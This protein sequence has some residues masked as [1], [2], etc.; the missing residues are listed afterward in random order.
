MTE[1]EDEGAGSHEHQGGQGSPV[2][3][4]S[5]GRESGGEPQ[6]T[7]TEVEDEPQRCG[8]EQA[9]DE[10]TRRGLIGDR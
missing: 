1:R 9:V 8:L 7:G 2:L 10:P 3:E 5:D 4:R 6:Q